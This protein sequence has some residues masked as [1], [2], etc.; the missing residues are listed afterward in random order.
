MIFKSLSTGMQI[1]HIVLGTDGFGV[2]VEQKDAFGMMDRYAELGGNT[3]DT[4]RIYG[5]QSPGGPSASEIVIGN[6]LA[7]RGGRD[8]IVLSSKCAHP[9]LG[10]MTQNR[11]S[12]REI[13]RDID[14]SLRML[15]TEYIDIMWLHRDDVKVPVAGI[16]DT[17]NRMVKKG[18]IRIFGASNWCAQRLADAQSYAHRSGQ[19]GFCASQIKWSAAITRPD[20]IDDPTLEEMNKAHY[21]YYKETKMPVFAYASQAKGFFSK[22]HAGGEAALSDKARARYLCKQNTDTYRKLLKLCKEL[23][24]SLAAAAVCTLTSNPDFATMAIAGCKN[25]AQLEDTMAGAD[26]TLPED[27]VKDIMGC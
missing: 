8:K 17:M 2:G 3:L 19:Q 27:I 6:W 24:I 21:N 22:Y 15:K 13:E 14:D 9:P 5:M 1:S 16:I 23:D 18:K 25:T 26:L 11:L 4:A 7:D 20:Y 12:E 10:N